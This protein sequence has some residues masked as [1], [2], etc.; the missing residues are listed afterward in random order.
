VLEGGFGNDR[1][2]GGDGSDRFVLTGT[3]LGQDRILDFAAGL[4]TLYLDDVARTNGA[5]ITSFGQLDTSGDGRLT[6]TDAPVDQL[7]EGLELALQGGTVLFLGVSEIGQE[8]V[9]IA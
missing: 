8:D 6:A 1:Q 4:D 3:V 2:T 7:A 9:L 5:T